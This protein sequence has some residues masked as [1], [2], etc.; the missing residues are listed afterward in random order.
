MSTRRKLFVSVLGAAAVA[1]G[2]GIRTALADGGPNP[3]PGYEIEAKLNYCA[4]SDDPCTTPSTFSNL[5]FAEV[6]VYSFKAGD[7]DAKPQAVAITCTGAHRIDPTDHMLHV[8]VM[9]VFA[10]PVSQGFDG[11]WIS[12]E[13][14]VD[15]AGANSRHAV[16]S[17]DLR[18]HDPMTGDT[19]E[20]NGWQA[21]NNQTNT[22]VAGGFAIEMHGTLYDE[23]PTNR[24]AQPVP[25]GKGE[26]KC[27]TRGTPLSLGPMGPPPPY[28]SDELG[29]NPS[30][31]S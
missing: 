16:A 1:L 27:T 10:G 23:Q 8:T 12:G 28:F 20:V 21:T 3:N 18:A 9:H 24:N 26:L 30:E 7:D 11:G 31:D 4:D 25:M 22:R 17:V 2:G 13:A 29:D 5:R 14:S 19:A 6:D 15:N